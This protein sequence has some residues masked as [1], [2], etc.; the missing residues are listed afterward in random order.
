M[1]CQ[2]LRREPYPWV[3]V[4]GFLESG[5]CER[6]VEGFDGSLRGKGESDRKA[7]KF[8]RYQSDVRK[9]TSVQRQF[10]EEVNGERFLGVLRSLTGIESL[11]GDMKLKGGGLH[12]SGDG[13]YLKV[14]TDF[15]QGL[16]NRH[17]ALNMLLFLNPEWHGRWGGCLELWSRDH[18]KKVHSVLPLMN[19]MVL[20]KT[21]EESFH[22]HPVPLRVPEGVKRR[23]LAVYYYEDWPKG[24]K[25]RN[26]TN[27]VEV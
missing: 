16:G 17:R 12:E 18:K 11:V 5:W 26:S 14:H 22:G 20:F 8:K 10:F 13:G 1:E 25:V 24:L 9:M 21:S 15:N 3:C 6:L 7:V 23:S 27:Y 2:V 19:R 4:D